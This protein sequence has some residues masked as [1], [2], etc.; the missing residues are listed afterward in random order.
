L[1]LAQITNG[2]GKYYAETKET[3]G[4]QNRTINSM[5]R[6]GRLARQPRGC[7]RV[8]TKGE[9]YHH[10]KFKEELG[11]LLKR[12]VFTEEKRQYEGEK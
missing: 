9:K 4:H 8:L 12:N 6:T 10:F 3:E 2:Y 7:S 5:F 1:T 11:H